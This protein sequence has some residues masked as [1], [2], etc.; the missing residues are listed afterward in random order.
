[1]NTLIRPIFAFV[2]TGA[3]L[4]ASGCATPQVTTENL[5]QPLEILVA[6]DMEGAQQNAQ[7]NAYYQMADQRLTKASYHIARDEDDK[8]R[9]QIVMAEADALVALELARLDGRRDEI[10][11]MSY[12]ENRLEATQARIEQQQQSDTTAS[13]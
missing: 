6:A 8:A 3:L 2:T 11:Q 7:A 9:R 5:K 13:R 1:M 10:T 12:L 4:L